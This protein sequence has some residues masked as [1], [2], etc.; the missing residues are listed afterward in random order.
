MRNRYEKYY[1]RQ[2]YLC[3][4]TEQVIQLVFQAGLPLLRIQG[5]TSLSGL[6][7]SAVYEEQ[8]LKVLFQAGLSLFR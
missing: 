5:T 8:V 2:D 6:T 4:A 1:F 3:H 7:N